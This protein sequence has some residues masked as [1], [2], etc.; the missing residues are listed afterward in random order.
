MTMC[1]DKEKQNV[2]FLLFIIEGAELWARS[3]S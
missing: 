3:V 2:S 1:V